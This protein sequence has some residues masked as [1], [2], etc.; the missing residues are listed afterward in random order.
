MKNQISLGALISYVTIIFNIILGIFYTPW[1]I[2]TIGDSEYALYTLA[3]SVINIFLMDFGLSSST[4]RFLSKYYAEGKEDAA[5]N[6]L[7]I[8]LKLYLIIDVIIFIVLSV[9]FSFLENIYIKLSPSEMSIFKNL[10]IIIAFYSVVSFPLL[11][12][13]GILMA[14][15][16]FIA[17]KFLGLFNKIVTTGL[18]V[19]A[20]LLNG[21]V[22]TLVLIN[23]GISVLFSFIKWF[24]VKGTGVK[25]N[26]R[27]KNIQLQKELLGF[28]IWL[29][30]AQMMQRCIFTIAPTFLAMFVN[31]TEIVYFSLA[32]TIEGYI[33]TIGD[34][35]NGM[36]LPKIA[37]LDTKE[38][39]EDNILEL[40]IKVGRFQIFVIGMIVVIF[41]LLGNHFVDSW[42]GNGYEKVSICTIFIILPLLLDL[43]QQIGKTTIMVRNKVKKQAQVYIIMA[44]VYIL[45]TI[46]FTQ[47]YGVVGTALAVMIA[48]FVR[49]ILLSFLYH[50]ELGLNMFTFYKTVYVR[51]GIVA[52]ITLCLGYIIATN[53]NSVGIV[54]LL[55]KCCVIA[56][57]Y[58]VVSY[59]FYFTNSEKLFIYQ[60]FRKEK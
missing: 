18:I 36:F 45:V 27:H 26:I 17:V 5:N 32:S 2:H 60:L 20:L 21:N 16:K 54:G 8:T 29:T 56:A 22:Y 14:K 12:F 47:K 57:I 24:L 50:K 31:S 6:F 49:S 4:S 7:G 34:A 15:E 40:M 37:M 55:I 42:M 13:N 38:N 59:I 11:N 46:F 41:I 53:I 25:F 48:Y 23:A 28:S 51:W 35:V 3:L 10:Y 39:S 44:M 9:V 1:M 30:V 52:G 33:W 43:P 19:V 58:I